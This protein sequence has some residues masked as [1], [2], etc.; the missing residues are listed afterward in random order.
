MVVTVAPPPPPEMAWVLIRT[1]HF[2][3]KPADPNYELDYGAGSIGWKW[4]LGE[5]RFAFRSTWTPPPAVIRP[6]D[7]ITMTLSC[8]ITENV[9][10]YYSANG[11]FDVWFDSPT[12]VPGYVERPIAFQGKPGLG[13]SFSVTHRKGVPPPQSPR[14]VWLDAKALGQGAEGAQIALIA[15]AFNGRL[16]GT[17]YVYEWKRVK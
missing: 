7:R 14:E 10:D 15:C 3:D 17:R 4:S 13:A 16:A 5:D 11:N 12:I 9:G 6:G 2:R 8:T 1:D